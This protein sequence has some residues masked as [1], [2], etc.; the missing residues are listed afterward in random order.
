MNILITGASRGIGYELV[1]EMSKSTNNTII[2]VSRNQDRLKHLKKK[3][4]EING[5][6]NV[7]ILSFDLTDISALESE[8]ISEIEKHISSIDVL[9]NNAGQLVNKSFS[10]FK[11]SDFDQCY[12]TNTK[13]PF[14]VIKTC[15]SL[16]S[17]DA[18]IV[19]IGSMG[20]VQGSV[21]FP[22]LSAYSSSK[23]ALAI[24]TECLAEEYKETK[25]CFNCLALGSAQTEMLEEAFPGY[26]A[27]MSA[28]KM[29]QFIGDFA[30]NGKK[31]F[32]GKVLP[33]ALTI[34]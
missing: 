25:L 1:L 20:G 32:N 7:Q 30:I 22:G 16:F 14:F 12:N 29:A 13:A 4:A 11:E 9:I 5:H 6:D 18:H 31:Y 33:V 8:F 26:K 15:I 34:P 10:E 19:N 21:K 2:A 3:C 24:L 27:P 17:H 28:N 23:G